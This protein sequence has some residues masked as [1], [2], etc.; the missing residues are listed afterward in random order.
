[1][2]LVKRSSDFR[3]SPPTHS[4]RC[5]VNIGGPG[6]IRCIMGYINPRWA[7]IERQHNPLIHYPLDYSFEFTMI[8]NVEIVNFCGVSWSGKGPIFVS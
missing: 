3:P 8:A 7:A 1:M 2:S 4:T 5:F 6:Y